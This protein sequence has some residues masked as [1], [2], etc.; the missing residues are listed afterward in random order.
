[1]N[2]YYYEVNLRVKD[3][4]DFLLEVLERNLDKPQYDF[5]KFEYKH[6]K[7]KAVIICRLHGAFLITPHDFLKGTGCAKCA[8]ERR[9]NLRTSSTDEF[10]EKVRSRGLDKPQYDFS[11]FE[12]TRSHQKAVIICR[13]HGDFLIIPKG[14]LAGKGCA[15]CAIER[16]ANLNTSSTD[17]FL[18]K[19]RSRG[20]NNP[21]YDFSKFEYKGSKKK[22]TIV[23]R[24]HGDFL[25]RPQD[26]LAGK[27]CARCTKNPHDRSKTTFVYVLTDE[28][29]QKSKIGVSCNLAV[30]ILKLKR[31]TPFKFSLFETF[32]FD[33]FDEAFAFEQC[34]HKILKENLCE[35][36][37]TFQGHTEWFNI[38]GENAVRLINSIL[39]DFYIETL[40]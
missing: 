31:K 7:K 1:M 4:M 30:R 8:T 34:V 11:K 40:D 18:E 36:K 16:R 33:N 2:Y 5:S 27:G 12:Y 20:L 17:E 15:K 37:E 3:T 38:T 32:E 10:L 22:A 13:K 23:C 35:F 21:N 19:A 28:E 26:F 29:D 25:I 6:S 24:K 39:P 9:A 14:F